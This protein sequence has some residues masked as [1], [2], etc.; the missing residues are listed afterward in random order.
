ME[1]LKIK[2]EFADDILKGIK[3]FEIRKKALPINEWI[4]MVEPDTLEVLGYVMFK[5]W[6]YTPNLYILE[7][8]YGY[9]IYDAD[10]DFYKNSTFKWIIDKKHY[11]FYQNYITRFDTIYIHVISKYSKTKPEGVE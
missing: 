3:T 10:G 2:K 7:Q 4:E 9:L 8:N 6:R 11:D 1:Q 5:F